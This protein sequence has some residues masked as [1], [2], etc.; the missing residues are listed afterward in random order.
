MKILSEYTAWNKPRNEWTQLPRV[1]ITVEIRDE[2]LEAAR[3]SED[4][5][6]HLDRFSTQVSEETLRCR[7]S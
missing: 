7:V 3:F 2:I 6:E 1:D 5:P 4:V